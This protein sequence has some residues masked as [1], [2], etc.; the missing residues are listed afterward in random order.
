[1]KV[2]PVNGVKNVVVVVMLLSL[3]LLTRKEEREHFLLTSCVI[4]M[5]HVP[6]SHFLLTSTK[7][8]ENIK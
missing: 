8:N 5:T 6:L 3:C 2:R 4:Y 7:V 1:M